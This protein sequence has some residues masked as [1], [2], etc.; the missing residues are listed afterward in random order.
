MRRKRRGKIPNIEPHLLLV[1]DLIAQLVGDILGL[2]PLPKQQPGS[3]NYMYLRIVGMEFQMEEILEKIKVG[4]NPQESF[5]QKNKDGD[6][7]S[8]IRGQVMHLN[9]LVLKKAPEEI[10][11]RKSEAPKNMR[12]KNNR[13]V[14][15]LMGKRL[16]IRMPP[17]DN[18]PRLK[19]MTLY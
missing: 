6:V 16:P 8:R 3:P 14:S 2:F 17:M 15:F 19:K 7:K 1:D 13:F 18:V 4:L 10:R 11:N 12:K 5:T 9:P